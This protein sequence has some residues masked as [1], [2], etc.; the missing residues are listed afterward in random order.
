MGMTYDNCLCIFRC[1]LFLFNGW[2][3]WSVARYPL[4]WLL[5]DKHSL[6]FPSSWMTLMIIALLRS[7]LM[8]MHSKIIRDCAN[9]SLISFV[10]SEVM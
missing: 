4:V 9:A 3:W 7:I 6:D 10:V 2:Y 8:I 1:I 5:Y